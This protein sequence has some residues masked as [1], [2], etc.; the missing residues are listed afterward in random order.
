MHWVKVKNPDT[1]VSAWLTWRRSMRL[2]RL[3][4]RLLSLLLLKKGWLGSSQY[5]LT[6]RGPRG[7]SRSRG[8]AGHWGPLKHQTASKHRGFVVLARH[9]LKLS[10][11]KSLPSSSWALVVGRRQSRGELSPR[12]ALTSVSLKVWI[13]T[14]LSEHRRCCCC[15]Q[16]WSRRWRS[17][18]GG[19]GARGILGLF[20]HLWD[21][22]R[23][24]FQLGFYL[25]NES[26]VYEISGEVGLYHNIFGVKL[27]THHED[28]L[29]QRR[30]SPMMIRRPFTACNCKRI[31]GTY[32]EQIK[33]K[34]NHEIKNIIHF[35][36][37]NA[38][39]LY[40]HRHSRELLLMNLRNEGM[41]NL[42]VFSIIFSKKSFIIFAHTNIR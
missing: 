34:L 24:Q 3:G 40:S 37:T 10:F 16:L 4:L 41:F 6:G 19:G 35:K 11:F 21:S 2:L 25:N 29:S 36:I 12:E 5:S 13:G 32:R 9:N 26:K 39:L 17:R 7:P 28:V 14:A 18:P 33:S 15:A 22:R 30:F 8:H 20:S 31:L 23:T 38:V 27:E 1:G 42:K